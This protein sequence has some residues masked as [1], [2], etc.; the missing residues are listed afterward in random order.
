VLDKEYLSGLGKYDVVYSWGVLHHTGHMW[1]AL[2]NVASLMKTDG[3][4]FIAIYNKQ[5]FLSVYWSLVKKMYNRSGALVKRMLNYGF[6]CF[7]VA[8]LFIADV[9]RFRN[10]A[11]RYSG[12]GR[13]GMS[14]YH[15]TIDWI[16][17]WPFE[18]ATP[19]EIFH[20]YKERG[21]VLSELVTCGG[22]HGCNQFVFKRV[23]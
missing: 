8:Q 4:L 9:L 11:V 14:I 2:E 7:F 3:S 15:D 23:A 19:E 12:A 18:V 1:E 5:Q 6:F 16:G 10:P 22:R 20:F 17:G 21:L 13:R